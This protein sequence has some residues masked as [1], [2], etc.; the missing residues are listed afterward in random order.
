MNCVVTLAAADERIS[1][2]RHPVPTAKNWQNTVLL[3]TCAK[4]GGLI[5]SLSRMVTRGDAPDDLLRRTE[6]CA[7]VHARILNATQ[8]GA[9]GSEI[10]FAAANAYAAAGFPD[11]I[12]LHHQGGAAGYKTREWVAHPESREI[13]RENQAFA[14]NPSI[15]GTKVE[16]TY[17][18]TGEGLELITGA[19]G[20]PRITTQIEGRQYSSP[21]IITI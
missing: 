16:D 21:G 17:V 6:A 9:T 13:I 7:N 18:A 1:Q 11:E 19:A 12:N 8:P 14:W 4:R 2:F 3:V 15:T 5:V 20:E 10:Y